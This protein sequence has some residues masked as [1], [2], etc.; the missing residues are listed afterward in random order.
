MK[1]LIFGAT[2]MVGQ[3]VLRECLLDSSVDKVV[4]VVRKPTGRI[5]EKLTELVQP[6]LATLASLEPQL[7]GFDACFFCVGV[8]ALGMSEA[9][10]TRLT[11]DL[12]LGVARTLLRTSPDLTFVYV[13]GT[14]TDSSE[15][16]RMMWARVKGRTENALLSMP[17]RAA[18]MFRP[19]VIMPL[20]GIRSSTRW[21]NI[22]Y[23][24]IGPIYPLLRRIA[25]SMI[26]TTEQLGRAM[27]AVARNGYST[28]VLETAGIN[29][30]ST[31]S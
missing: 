12:T 8:S 22:G 5:H 15:K 23:A 4:T 16:G 27:I 9:E 26:T 19:G 17:F 24:V 25:P 11:Y 2:G 1:V 30:L 13:S 14:G 21:Y 28:H 29:R 31:W 10:Y 7:T 6:D 20:H 3:G 18:Y